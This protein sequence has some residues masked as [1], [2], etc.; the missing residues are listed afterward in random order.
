MLLINRSALRYCLWRRNCHH[1]ADS[2][3]AFATTSATVDPHT[4]PLFRERH[5]ITF[6][7]IQYMEHASR[8]KQKLQQRGIFMVRH[9]PKITHLILV[10][11]VLSI[12][13][14]AFLLQM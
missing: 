5:S 10:F 3:V 11:I 14:K 1:V 4:L 13:Q 9:V 6:D 8:K 2:L 12:I 7:V